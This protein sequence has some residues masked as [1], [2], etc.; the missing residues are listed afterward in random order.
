MA[1]R[2]YIEDFRPRSELVVPQHKVPRAKFPVVD[3]HNHVTYPHFGWD[4]RPM[5]EIISELDFLNVA[6]V[7]NLSGETGDVLKRNLEKLD[8]V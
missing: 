7:V 5:A 3:A 2:I 8:Q 1:D 4:E 6:T